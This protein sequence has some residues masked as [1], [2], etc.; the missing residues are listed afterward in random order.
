MGKRHLPTAAFQGE[1][2]SLSSS[3]ITAMRH[4]GPGALL[5]RLAT[6]T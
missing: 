6:C 3:P 2:C 4:T 1:K 5:P